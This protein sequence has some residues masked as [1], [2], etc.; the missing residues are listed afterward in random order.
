MSEYVIVWNE[1]KNEGVIFRKRP[2]GETCWERGSKSDALHASG[3]RR[4]NPCSSLADNFREIYGE[5]QPCTIQ[6]VDIDETQSVS[7]RSFAARK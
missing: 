7:R 4:C 2:E 6:T 3:G 5:E 1:G